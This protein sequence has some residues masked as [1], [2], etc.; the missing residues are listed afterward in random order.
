[1][2]LSVDRIVADWIAYAKYPTPG[3]APEQVATDGSSM[4][5]LPDEQPELAWAAIKQIVG[6]YP[7]AE[8]LSAEDTEAKQVVG[9][10]AAGPLEDLLG[11][12]GE[13]FID[14][15][16]EEVRCDPRMRWAL[17]GVWQFSMSDDLWSRVQQAARPE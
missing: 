6:R 10:I 13:D 17:N 4:Y 12:H 3:D 2:D 1:M 16:E 8:L 14:R 11:Y 5:E 9:R 7:N 15:I